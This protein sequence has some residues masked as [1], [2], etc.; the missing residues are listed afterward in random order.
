MM[1]SDI[2]AFLI[3]DAPDIKTTLSTKNRRFKQFT[4][5]YLGDNEI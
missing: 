1:L 4:P 5:C 2:S 3:S